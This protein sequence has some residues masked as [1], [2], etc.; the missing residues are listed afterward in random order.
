MVTPFNANQ[1]QYNCVCV[2]FSR[3][4]YVFSTQTNKLARINVRKKNRLFC[5]N[6]HCE[7]AYRFSFGGTDGDVSN[8]FNTDM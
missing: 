1:R 8:S 4:I 7:L 6:P 2:S 5:L 3:A